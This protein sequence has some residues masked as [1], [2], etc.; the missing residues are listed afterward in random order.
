MTSE[1][2]VQVQVVHD[3]RAALDEIIGALVDERLIACGH[4]M[5]PLSSTFFWDGAVQ[6]E[7][8]W[9]ALLKTTRRTVDDLIAR[10]VELHSYEV[11][12]IL[13]LEIASGYAPYLGWVADRTAGEQDID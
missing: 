1:P 2:I 12:E 5:G 11:P 10:L 8:E 13:V 9:L 6:K 7:E 3:D 4:V